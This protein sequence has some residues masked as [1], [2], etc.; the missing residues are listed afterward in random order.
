MSPAA[1]VLPLTIGGISIREADVGQLTHIASY[2]GADEALNAALAQAH[3]LGWPGPNQSL[4]TDHARIIWFGRDAALLAGPAPQGGL[5]DHAA[6]ADQ[7]DAWA[8]IE[9][10]G[11]ALD[12]VMARL[13]PVDLR[14]HVFAVGQ[15]V[16]SQI[17]HMN[18][19]VTRLAEDRMLILVFRS[20][21]KT[22]VHDLQE[23]IEGMT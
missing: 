20:M 23:A 3:G 6:L 19:S 15:T 2:A 18:G 21:A 1:G 22:L 17:Q 5:E 7:S 13:V 10:E 4:S 14:P 9:I 11:P 8:A 16:R 12:Q